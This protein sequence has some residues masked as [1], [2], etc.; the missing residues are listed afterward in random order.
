VHAQIRATPLSVTRFP[1]G[2]I[3]YLP[4]NTSFTCRRRKSWPPSCS[5]SVRPSRWRSDWRRISS[6]PLRR[7]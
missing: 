6:D 5:A 2:T 1:R 7:V 4:H 3:S